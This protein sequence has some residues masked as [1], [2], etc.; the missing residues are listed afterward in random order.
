[1]DI[2]P[3]LKTKKTYA[4]VAAVLVVCMALSIYVALQFSVNA[5]LQDQNPS[6]ANPTPT[7]IPTVQ[8][9]ST[10]TPDPTVANPTPHPLLTEAQARDIAMPLIQK[11]ATDTN[12]VVKSV[13]AT[14]YPNSRDISGARSGNPNPF[15][16][17]P[18]P[19]SLPS[20]PE[21]QVEAFFE[22]TN[23]SYAPGHKPSTAEG[24]IYG[25][26]VLIWADNGQIRDATPQGIM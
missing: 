19:Q 12:R 1:L 9:I 22:P 20:Y 7:I 5:S 13:N 2:K 26:S 21:W 8:P 17:V 10:P 3:A 23:D 14:F 4:I 18:N 15:Q 16:P 25:Y 11:Y 6:P 24:W